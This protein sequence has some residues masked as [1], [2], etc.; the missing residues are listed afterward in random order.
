MGRGIPASVFR[1]RGVKFGSEGSAVRLSEVSPPQVSSAKEGESS[2]P[3]FA[4]K[5]GRGARDRKG[6]GLPKG[7]QGKWGEE[8]LQPRR[9]PG[10]DGPRTGRAPPS[11]PLC[12]FRLGPGGPWATLRGDPPLLYGSHPDLGQLSREAPGKGLHSSRSSAGTLQDSPGRVQLR[13]PLQRIALS[14]WAAGLLSTRGG[15][16]RGEPVWPRSLPSAQGLLKLLRKWEEKHRRGSGLSLSL[17]GVF[18]AGGPV[19][20]PPE[21]LGR[22]ASQD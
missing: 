13:A 4:G 16:G 5:G 6:M 8:T 17:A 1:A 12:R 10:K 18:F 21:R 14:L 20:P 11:L 19:R 2:F 22:L 15:P 9:P 3:A 7:A